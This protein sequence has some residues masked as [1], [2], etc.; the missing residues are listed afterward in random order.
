MKSMD[1][2][3]DQF[4]LKLVIWVYGAKN[5]RATKKVSCRVFCGKQRYKCKAVRQRED[6]ECPIWNDVLFFVPNEDD[7]VRI[8]LWDEHL[9]GDVFLGQLSLGRLDEMPMEKVVA[10]DSPIEGQSKHRRARVGGYL[11]IRYHLSSMTET[12]PDAGH[13]DGYKF[14]YEH[15]YSQFQTG[16]LLLYNTPDLVSTLVK[17]STLQPFSRVGMIVKLPNKYTECLETYVVEITRNLDGFLDAF[18]ESGNRMGM[19]IFRCQERIHHIHGSE[20][21]YCPMKTALS[22]EAE[23]RLVEYIWEEHGHRKL[24]EQLHNPVSNVINNSF[25]YVKHSYNLVDLTDAKVFALA[26]QYAG[27]LDFHQG[28]ITCTPDLLELGLWKRGTI[29]RE[30][31][32]CNN[33][34]PNLVHTWQQKKLVHPQVRY[35]SKASMKM[36]RLIKSGDVI[37][38][39]AIQS[40]NI[41][42]NDDESDDSPQT[43]F[44][45][46]DN[47]R[48][49][50]CTSK[51]DSLRSMASSA[52][53][54]EFVDNRDAICTLQPAPEVK[55]ADSLEDRD[56]SDA[57]QP[58]PELSPWVQQPGQEHEKMKIFVNCG[59]QM[60][61]SQVELVRERLPYATV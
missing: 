23:A 7:E 16:D 31:L 2:L 8:E 26:F 35:E 19:N 25:P 59:L 20:I 44:I 30:L 34:T 15:L 29:I 1:R 39:T 37:E 11:N 9:F 54:S 40:L 47:E 50:A 58:L 18:A 13:P 41:P 36:K 14:S 6:I 43:V 21:W 10:L 4:P 5:V 60:P 56:L 52:A 32:S 28:G 48:P 17:L 53:A 51:Q 42:D 57:K 22:P 38:K 3:W 45:V 27:V 24:P 12:R 55:A 61:R 33:E 49:D 46:D